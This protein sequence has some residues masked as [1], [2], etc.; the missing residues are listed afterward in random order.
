MK[1]IARITFLTLTG[2]ACSAQAQVVNGNFGAGL[3]GWTVFGD[4]ITSAGTLTLTTAALE[5]PDTPF[6]LSGTS[7]VEYFALTVAA[8]VA[9]AAFDLSLEDFATEGSLVQQSF[10]VAAGQT[11]SFSWSFNTSETQLLD[12]AFVVLNG[13][14]NTLATR[15]NPGAASQSFSRTF[16]QGGPVKLSFGVVDTGDYNVVSKLNISNVQITPVPEPA[17]W[18]MWGLGLGG[19]MMTRRRA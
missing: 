9:P 8:S 2:L 18:L 5:A 4:A 10:V 16:T 14:V 17:T 19:L 13:Q 12:H 6:N 15:A 7:A 1:A 11:L 3:A